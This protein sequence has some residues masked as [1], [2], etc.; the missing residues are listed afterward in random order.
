M[1]KWL[2]DN[3]KVICF[4][5]DGTIV[6]TE[7][8]YIMAFASVLEKQDTEVLYSD[9]YG[10]VGESLK[11]KWKR[12][13]REGNIKGSV[14]VDELTFQTYQEFLKKLNES[15]IEPVEGFWN[16]MFKLKEEK[17][18]KVALTTNTIKDVALK[19][20]DK[21]E[22]T[23]AFDFVIFGDDVKRK[24]PDPEIYEKTAQHFGVKTQEMLVFEDSIL[25][26]SAASGSGAS[27]LVVWDGQTDKKLFPAETIYFIND[28]ED[29]A[30]SLDTT[31]EEEIENFRK[32]LEL[33]EQNK[34]IKK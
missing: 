19:V 6:K 30:K 32:Q 8:Y 7:P 9:V 28:F 24:K 22:I 20:M 14:N 11:D 12:V 29:L 2:L 31:A 23:N 17:Q 1:Y 18:L 21:L 25:G 26:S 13:V 16:I 27:L 33:E 4:D 10:V 15:N 3:K 5:L 34:S